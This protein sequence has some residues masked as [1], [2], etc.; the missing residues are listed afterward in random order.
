MQPSD[1]NN[2][3]RNTQGR[4]SPRVGGGGNMGMQR[5]GFNNRRRGG[6]KLKQVITKQQN[7]DF[8]KVDTTPSIVNYMLQKN[9]D[10]GGTVPYENELTTEEFAKPVFALAYL[11][12]EQ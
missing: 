6:N 3:Q 1:H 9:Y 7:P 8:L 10:G 11:D 2:W 12:T 4:T 5:M